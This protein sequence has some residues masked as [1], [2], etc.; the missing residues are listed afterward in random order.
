MKRLKEDTLIKTFMIFVGAVLFLL[1][2]AYALFK[3]FLLDLISQNS[4]NAQQVL[5]DFNSLFV[6]IL[7][8]ALL[9]STFVFYFLRKINAK[10]TEDIDE[11][12]NYVTEISEHKNYDAI[13]KIK[14]Y[15]EFLEIS[16]ILKNIVKRLKQ[17]TKKS[18]KK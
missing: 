4:L 15:T 5:L 9:V 7:V 2:S 14:D 3:N 8:V 16:L 1:V 13:I 17:K 12:K 11:I 10:L 6:V 18:S